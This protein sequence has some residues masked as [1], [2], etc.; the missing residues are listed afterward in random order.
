MIFTSGVKDF[1]KAYDYFI[2][3]VWGVVHDGNTVY[4]GAIEAISFLR[5]QGKKICFL[6]NAPRRSSK[7][8]EV[9][10]R[11]GI[12]PNLYDF[13][14]TSGEATF[15]DLK[16]NQENGFKTFGKNYF[17]I[18]PTKDI[19]LLDGLDYVRVSEASQANFTLTTGFDND[20]S[21]LT[22]KLPLALE[23]KKFNLPMIC[24]NPDMI[25]VR[26][27]G[28][29]LICA[30][31]LAREYEKIGGKVFYYGKPFPTVYKMVCEIFNNLET[32]PL[33]KSAFSE[34][35]EGGA[36]HRTAAYSNIREDSS[37]APTAQLPLKVGFKKRSTEKMIAIGD[38]L[39]TDIKGSN[40]AGIDSVLVTGG[41]LSNQLQIKFWQDASESKLKKI[42]YS[43]ETFPKFIISNLKI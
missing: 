8:L 35:L 7:V 3:D 32:A 42:C 12:T 37:S 24:V 23:A 43:Y 34:K 31:T 26:Q 41:I 18:G 6:S 17:Y 22:E 10:N 13:I 38:G 9:F 14:L 21:V 4:P 36:Q 20:N 5:D 33:F 1:A 27:S 30:G 29:E 40:D 25:V 19:D 11:L 15:L 2:F 16:K 28:H 39:E